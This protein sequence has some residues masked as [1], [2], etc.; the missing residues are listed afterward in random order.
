MN[1]HSVMKSLANGTEVTLSGDEAKELYAY[2]Q[3]LQQLA[4]H[5]NDHYEQLVKET[6]RIAGLVQPDMNGE[7]MLKMLRGLDYSEVCRV[8]KAFAGQMDRLFP[9]ISQL[10]PA[11]KK[12]TAPVADFGNF[13]I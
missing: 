5:G 6:V 4:R 3:N 12:E 10:E 11:Q 2:L 13:L 9:P 7:L 1:N 8:N